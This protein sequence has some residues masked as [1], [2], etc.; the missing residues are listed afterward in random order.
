MKKSIII[1]A[2]VLLTLNVAQAQP[3]GGGRD[4]KKMTAKV[5]DK[6]E[7]TTEQQA[8]LKALNEKYPGTDY[9]KMKYREDFRAILTDKQKAELDEMKQKRQARRQN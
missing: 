9:D 1:A 5:A 7:F 3:Q 4:P 8:R 2:A 6:L